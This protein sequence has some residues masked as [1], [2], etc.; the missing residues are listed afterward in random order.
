MTSS[1]VHVSD[2]SIRKN[3]HGSVAGPPAR[4]A[5]DGDGK[6]DLGKIEWLTP[7]ISNGACYFTLPSGEGPASRAQVPRVSLPLLKEIQKRDSHIKCGF[8]SDGVLVIAVASLK[9]PVAIPLRTNGN[10]AGRWLYWQMRGRGWEPGRYSVE[11]HDADTW[12]V[13][14]EHKKGGNWS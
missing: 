11:R 1:S 4:L 14:R 12:V 9:T 5:Y 7:V 2:Q 3:G 10:I 13:R 6:I 8:A